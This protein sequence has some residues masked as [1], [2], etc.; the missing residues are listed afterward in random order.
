VLAASPRTPLQQIMDPDPPIVMGGVD[1]EVAAWRAI[2]QRE[3]SLA[4]VDQDRTFM[5]LI[6]PRRI[7][8]VLLWE[9][10]ED[11][12]RLGGFI[13]GSSDAITAIEE[14]LWRRL[15]HRVPWLLAGLLGAVASSDVVGLF[16]GQIR[17][18]LI[19]TFFVPG[20]VY[21][22]DAVG[23]QTESLVIRGLSVGVGIQRVFLREVMTG[24]MIGMVLAVLMFLF[25][26]WRWQRTDVAFAV[27]TSLL[28]ACSIASGIAS[29]LPWLLQRFGQDPAFAAGPIATVIQDLISVLLYFLICVSIV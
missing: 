3:T 22:A 28:A 8:E 23:T 18:E 24:V 7:F 1:Q 12:A 11:T 4:V 6:T 20:I 2:R 21:L 27:A 9:H 14:S 17:N 13:K 25:V 15:W 29:A 10:D 26:G 5:G 16:A 19:L